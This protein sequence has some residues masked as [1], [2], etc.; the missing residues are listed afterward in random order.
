MVAQK[1]IGQGHV[2]TAKRGRQMRP[3]GQLHGSSPQRTRLLPLL[4]RLASRHW[5]SV[6]VQQARSTCNAMAHLAACSGRALC[7]SRP[8]L[9]AQRT[10]VVARPR[11]VRVQRSIPAAAAAAARPPPADE[12][13]SGGRGSGS[14]S[15]PL[16][17]RKLARQ[18]RVR[19]QAREARIQ[20]QQQEMPGERAS[21][22]S[23]MDEQTVQRVEAVAAELL[24]AGMSRAGVVEL[25]ESMQ[26]VA[27]LEPQALAPKLASTRVVVKGG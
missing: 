7:A 22:W 18:Q 13:S 16:S 26:A 11:C 1:H 15:P 8:S 4:P 17:A 9:H 27:S 24:G 20:L 10:A 3:A 21:P 19:Q 14:S 23:R 12:G 5:Q 2:A 25:L 6:E